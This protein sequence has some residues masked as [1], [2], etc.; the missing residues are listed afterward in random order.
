M[1]LFSPS[2]N[3][4][5]S[6]GQLLW[7]LFESLKE[8]SNFPLGK[9]SSVTLYLW[10]IFSLIIFYFQVE[11]VFGFGCVCTQE[12]SPERFTMPHMVVTQLSFFSFLSRE[13]QDMC[14][15]VGGFIKEPY[16]RAWEFSLTWHI[17]FSLQEVFTFMKWSLFGV[18]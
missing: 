18:F 7:E 3:M 16:S 2:W 6:T 8:I 15:L 11:Y 5:H 13:T 4:C 14:Q 10:S 1:I 17:I 12:K 9:I